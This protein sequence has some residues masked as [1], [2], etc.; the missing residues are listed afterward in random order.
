MYDIVF[1]EMGLRLPF[2]DFEVAV[3][4]D[5]RLAPSQLHPND[6]TFMRVFEI[7]CDYLKIGA[8]IPFFFYYFHLQRSKI[9]GK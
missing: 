5:L 8:T 9:D 7:V 4:R 6:I 3:F 1:W 2:S